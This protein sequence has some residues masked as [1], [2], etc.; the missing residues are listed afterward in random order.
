MEAITF[1]LMQSVSQYFN[2]EIVASWIFIA[3]GIAGCIVTIYFL[4]KVK[5]PVYNGIAYT[6]AVISLIQLT[7]GFTLN[8]RLPEYREKI[9]MRMAGEQGNISL[10]EVPR[11]ELLLGQ[12]SFYRWTSIA[13]LTVGLLIFFN[14][15]SSTSWKGVG[16]GLSIESLIML[17][18]NF[19]AEDRNT[20][21][22]EHLMNV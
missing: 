9:E 17:A 13:L 14:F 18:M 4:L 1:T 21:F 15:D 11:L 12:L 8:S 7:V 5:K 3:L 2:G 20:A 22:M 10:E 6:V 19:W 16:I